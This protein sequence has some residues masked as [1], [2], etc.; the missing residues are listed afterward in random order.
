MR[1]CSGK[2][3]WD[4]ERWGQGG[5]EKE[6]DEEKEE[7]EE[8]EEEEKW[9]EKKEIEWSEEVENRKS[10]NSDSPVVFTNAGSPSAIRICAM[11]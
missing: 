6:E 8:E 1:G 4:E 5:E 11:W 9:K 10:S 2:G 7:E 3:E